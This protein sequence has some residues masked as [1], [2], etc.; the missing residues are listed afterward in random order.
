MSVYISQCWFEDHTAMDSRCRGAN[1]EVGGEAGDEYA[2]CWGFLKELRRF[3]GRKG[4]IFGS[5]PIALE[6]LT[7]NIEG[8]NEADNSRTLQTYNECYS[9]A[10]SRR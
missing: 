7:R 1:G 10:P 5:W 3:R 8:R 4:G 6:S 9:T 2:L